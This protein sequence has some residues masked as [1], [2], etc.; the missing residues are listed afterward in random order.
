MGMM[1]K[2]EIKKLRKISREA[3]AQ[4]WMTGKELRLLL[5]ENHPEKQ[6]KY[7][8]TIWLRTTGKN[9]TRLLPEPLPPKLKKFQKYNRM[10]VMEYV[11]N[12]PEQQQM[13]D[14]L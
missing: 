12:P 1:T 6:S 4:S 8:P 11:K 9:V 10:Q 13:R 5:K 7:S 2:E 14:W 3:P